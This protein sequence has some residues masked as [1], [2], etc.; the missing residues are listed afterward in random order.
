MSIRQDVVARI[1]NQQPKRLPAVQQRPS[2]ICCHDRVSY[3]SPLE[4]AELQLCKEINTKFGSPRL[5]V[6]TES[7]GVFRALANP[8]ARAAGSLTRFSPSPSSGLR[9]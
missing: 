1:V 2:A 5:T 7:K 9:A 3:D 8:A 6:G 4:Q